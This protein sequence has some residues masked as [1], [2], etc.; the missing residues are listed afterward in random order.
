MSDGPVPIPAFQPTSMHDGALVIERFDALRVLFLEFHPRSTPS[1]VVYVETKLTAA[2]RRNVE[3]FGWHDAEVIRA[4][5]FAQ[6]VKDARQRDE[7][8][9]RRL[10]EN[11]GPLKFEDTPQGPEVVRAAQAFQ[12]RGR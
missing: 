10:F 9:A 4:E 6:A 8:N 3:L 11:S 1:H 2:H 5:A 7:E 12:G